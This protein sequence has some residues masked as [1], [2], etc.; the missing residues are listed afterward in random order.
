MFSIFKKKSPQEESE[1]LSKLQRQLD[2][3]N[4]SSEAI[5]AETAVLKA[6]NQARR[7]RL[8]EAGIL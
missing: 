3:I 6:S 2:S 1:I 7:K 8:V 4:N 5:R